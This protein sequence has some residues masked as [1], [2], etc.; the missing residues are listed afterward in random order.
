MITSSKNITFHFLALVLATMLVLGADQNRAFAAPDPGANVPKGTEDVR[1]DAEVGNAQDKKG[2][3]PAQPAQPASAN[4]PVAQLS[5]KLNEAIDLQNQGLYEKAHPLIKGLCADFL[6][7]AGEKNPETGWCFNRLA[8]LE[9]AMGQY[10]DAESS[11][12]QALGLQKGALPENHADILSTLVDQGELLRLRGRLKEAQAQLEDVLDKCKADD[13]AE[14]RMNAKSNLAKVHEDL[15]H[16]EDAIKLTR[17]ILDHEIKTLGSDHPNPLTTLNN[18]AGLNRRQGN[19]A[20]AEKNYRQALSGFQKALGPEHPA[21]IALMNNLAMTMEDEGLYD[22]AEPL[23]RQSWQL[24]EK[25]LGKD[26]PTTLTNRNNLAMLYES[27]G[28]FDKAEAQYNSTIPL[29]EAKLGPTHPDTIAM[30]NNLAFL[31]LLKEDHKLAVEGFQRVLSVWQGELGEKHQ[32]TLKAMNNLARAE[33]KAGQLKEA[34]A[35]LLRTL[36]LRK[37]ALGPKH[38]DALRSMLDLGMLY[39]SQKKNKEAL[40][41]LKSALALDEEVLGKQHPYTFETL[42]ALAQ[43]MEESSDLQGAYKLRHEGF[44]R[45][46]TFLNRMLWVADEN[47]REGYIRLHSPELNNFLSLITHL[48]PEVAGR[49]AIDVSLQRKGLLLKITSEIQQVS[50]IAKDPKLAEL[51]QQLTAARKELAAMTLSGP[52]A[53][54]PNSYLETIHR[55][56]GKVNDIERL[57]GQ[58]SLRYRYTTLLYDTDQVAANL[59]AGS[60]LVD[61]LVFNQEGKSRLMASTM[62]IKDGKPQ[63]NLVVYP[64]LED[65]QKAVLDYR[66]KIQDEEADS[67]DVKEFGQ[68]VYDLVWKPVAASLGDREDIYLVPD[69]IL[70]ILPFNALVDAD[71]KFLIQKV[72][73]HILTSSRD[74]LPSAIP[75]ATGEMMVVA[76]PDYNSTKV[77]GEVQLEQVSQRRAAA[78]MQGIRGAGSGMRGLHFDPLPGAEK[79]GRLI[80]DQAKEKGQKN[81]FFVQNDA[82]EKLVQGLSVPPRMIHIAT[83][84]FFLKPDDSLRKRLL[85]LQRG[86]E[87]QLPPPGDNPLL[88]SGLAFAGINANAPYLGE[89]DTVNDGVLT[90]LE[91]L[92]LNLAGTE[93]AIL[94]ACETGLGEIHE[95]EGV[96]GLRRA[97]METGVRS[98]IASLWEV[99]DAG[100]QNLMTK[101]YGRLM[102]GKTVHEAMRESQLEMIS[103]AEW[104]NPYIWSAF[105]LIGK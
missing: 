105:M 5:A 90:A 81:Q 59:P 83:H 31:R 98:L 85:K 96:Y 44:D 37:E 102:S 54:S 62:V 79:E 39:R 53:D 78:V 63:F 101:F 74:I 92:G 14:V 68:K 4:S 88:R 25:V 99:S 26:H 61:F 23:F 94:S 10:D 97:F 46:T 58:A 17:E 8:V 69:G 45:R 21:T 20:E 43:T 70:N 33:H 29:A 67:Q 6:K 55:L 27:Q 11:F 72:K 42:N 7:E 73:L 104:S 65:V 52:S 76:G 75:P 95:G 18:L 57:L 1:K 87:G 41:L 35:L 103:S 2:E 49:E 47:A 38:P 51:T 22:Q 82:Q 9:G 71:K 32:K 40:E 3:A 16:F 93:L 100:T 60:G 50:Q 84:G 91:V 19:F 36:S 66:A 28:L 86:A 13:L 77:A 15:G 64:S 34:E 80:I 56:E 48:S 89:L 24:A 12:K 30:V